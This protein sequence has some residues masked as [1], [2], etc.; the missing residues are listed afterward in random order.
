M[1][2][3]VNF[4]GDSRENATAVHAEGLVRMLGEKR[5][6]ILRILVAQYVQSASE[7]ILICSIAKGDQGSKSQ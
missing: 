7:V 1:A 5:Q 4:P 2:V 6:K 3:H